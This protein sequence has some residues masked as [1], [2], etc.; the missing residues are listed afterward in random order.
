MSPGSSRSIESNAICGSSGPPRLVNSLLRSGWLNA[1]SSLISPC[2]TNTS[3]IEWSS[4]RRK[5][6]P[7]RKKYSRLSPQCAQSTRPLLTSAITQVE[8]GSRLS[9]RPF[10][11]TRSWAARIMPSSQSLAEPVLGSKVSNIGITASTTACEAR[12][13]PLCPPIPSASTAMSTSGCVG[14]VANATR[15]CCSLRSPMFSALA[16]S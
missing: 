6:S 12:A 16:N 4:V 7:W 14:W 15:S 10:A 9:P 5:N 11:V 2:L 13:P 3:T 1:S 8:R